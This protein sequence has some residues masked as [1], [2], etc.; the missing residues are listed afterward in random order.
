MAAYK[1]FRVV[2]LMS[3]LSRT[4][5]VEKGL[6]DQC[7]FVLSCPQAV[8]LQRERGKEPVV[9]WLFQDVLSCKRSHARRISKTKICCSKIKKYNLIDLENHPNAKLL[10]ENCGLAYSYRIYGG[11]F[12]DLEEFPWMV[13]IAYKV[14]RSIK[15]KCGGSLITA[16]Y[17]LTASHCV[18][19]RKIARWNSMSPY[20]KGTTKDGAAGYGGHSYGLG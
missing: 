9:Q 14:K 2:V 1:M 5:E 12:A 13:V 11:T 17:V 19:G 18:R 10:P 8:R 4:A 20:N 7:T 3:C 16:R 6:C 15:F